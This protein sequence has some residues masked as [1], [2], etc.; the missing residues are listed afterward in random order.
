[1]DHFTSLYARDNWGPDAASPA[2][3]FDVGIDFLDT[4][5]QDGTLTTNAYFYGAPS[6]EYDP[7]SLPGSGWNAV[8][9]GELAAPP[10]T[11]AAS[12]DLLPLVL[13][14]VGARVPETD[15]VTQQVIDDVMNGTGP[16]D[17]AGTSDFWFPEL[18]AGTSPPDADEDGMPDD[19]ERAHALDPSDP[20][21]GSKVHPNGYTNV[22]NYLNE[23]AGDPVPPC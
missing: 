13:A 18:A 20:S 19:W 22:E 16:G 10:V 3:G 15:A 11:T 6:N 17:V 8:A 2:D 5:P 21:D 9:A 12:V 7:A 23:L 14:T 1:M 4:G